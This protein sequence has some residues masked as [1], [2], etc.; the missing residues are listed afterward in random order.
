MQRHPGGRQGRELCPLQPQLGGR[1]RPEG[2][3]SKRSSCWQVTA[4]WLPY[5]LLYLII[6]V[7]V[8]MRQHRQISSECPGSRDKDKP[9]LE[10][11]L[12]CFPTSCLH[13]S[14]NPGWQMCIPPHTGAAQPSSPPH[15]ERQANE[16]SYSSA[17]ED[18]HRGQAQQTVPRANILGSKTIAAPEEGFG[19]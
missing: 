3:D 10:S 4:T 19:R 2:K 17:N 7:P 11:L 6:H 15:A 16:Q 18:Q 13:K 8:E 14:F 9:T 5:F 12:C 1:E